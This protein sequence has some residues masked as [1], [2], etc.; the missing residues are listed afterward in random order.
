MLVGTLL[1]ADHT[2]KYKSVAAEP[3]AI[4]GH[5]RAIQPKRIS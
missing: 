4:G 1:L 2:G 3:G 5:D